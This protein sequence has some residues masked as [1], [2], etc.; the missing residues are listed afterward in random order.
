RV[1][2]VTFGGGGGVLA[3]DLCA[4]AGLATPQLGDATRARVAPLLPPIA[5]LA[6]PVD[7]TPATFQPAWIGKFPD[8]LAAIADDPDIDALFLPL[9]A[10]A[11]GGADVARALVALRERAD[12]PLCV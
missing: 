3:A 12:K 7:V 5:S 11:H 8:A 2:I 6:N 9:S 1:A 10:M 4:R